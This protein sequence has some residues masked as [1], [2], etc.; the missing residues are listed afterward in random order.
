MRPTI[1][2][3]GTAGKETIVRMSNILLEKL[4]GRG[5][6]APGQ[7]E[8]ILRHIHEADTLWRQRS[9]L[10]QALQPFILRDECIRKEK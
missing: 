5:R 3:V 4:I 10:Q 6:H 1:T 9:S 8:E 2:I 7:Q